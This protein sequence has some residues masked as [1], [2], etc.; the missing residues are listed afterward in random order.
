MQCYNLPRVTLSPDFPYRGH[1]P[2]VYVILEGSG[3]TFGCES[4]S[5]KSI[6]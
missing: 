6:K 5:Q 4:Q 3:N 2:R 1:Q